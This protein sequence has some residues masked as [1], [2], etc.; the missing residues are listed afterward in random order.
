MR[1]FH[2]SHTLSSGNTSYGY[3]MKVFIAFAREKKN[4]KN[5]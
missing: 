4:E 2:K 3:V 5:A 1:F